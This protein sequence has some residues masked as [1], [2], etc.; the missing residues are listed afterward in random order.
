MC[1]RRSG[2]GR[3]PMSISVGTSIGALQSAFAQAGASI[4]CPDCQRMLQ[5]RVAEVT[6]E[7]AA[8][9]V[10]PVALLVRLPS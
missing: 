8:V 7:W 6:Q 1:V 10:R 3:Q 9:K 2:S 5:N 4:V